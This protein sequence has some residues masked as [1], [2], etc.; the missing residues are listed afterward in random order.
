MKSNSDH[1]ETQRYIREY[2]KLSTKDLKSLLKLLE[3][4]PFN[5]SSTKNKID[6][7]KTLLL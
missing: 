2:N 1:K 7:V 3:S 5:R 4:E 6:A